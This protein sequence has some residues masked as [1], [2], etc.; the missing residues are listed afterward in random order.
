MYEVEGSRERRVVIGYRMGTTRSYFSALSDL[1]HFYGLFSSRKYVEQFSNGVTVITLYLNPMPASKSPP[2]ELSIHQVRALP[3]V[4]CPLLTS[5]CARRSSRRRRSSLCCPTTPSSSPARET[6]PSK[7]PRTPTVAGSLRS[8]CECGP[9]RACMP[10]L[11]LCARSCNRLGQAYQALRN[12]LD[13][14]DPAHASILNDIKLR[15]RE[16]TFTRQSIQEVSMGEIRRASRQAN[17][18]VR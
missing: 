5:L 6:T 16:E 13:E 7:K 12:V 11:T 2:I 1:Y 18:R 3:C 17:P 10:S 14:A 15:F 9:L 4:S 8:T